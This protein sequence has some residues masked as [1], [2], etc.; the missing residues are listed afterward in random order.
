MIAKLASAQSDAL[1][2]V[3]VLCIMQTWPRFCFDFSHLLQLYYCS[4]K[5]YAPPSFRCHSAPPLIASGYAIS[6]RQVPSRYSSRAS[7]HVRTRSRPIRQENI[8]PVRSSVGE[9][10]L[11]CRLPC[12]TLPAHRMLE[13]TSN[14]ALCRR[15]GDMSLED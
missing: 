3:V 6:K 14:G 4:C 10:R 11:H 13:R 7:Q 9:V 1:L 15:R 5:P 2:L 8:S 12:S